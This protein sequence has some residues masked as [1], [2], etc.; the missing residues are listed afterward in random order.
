MSEYD[1]FIRQTMFVMWLYKNAFLRKPE[2]T[3]ALHANEMHREEFT[4]EELDQ[5]CNYMRAVEKES[6]L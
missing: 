4:E 5:I 2:T 3:L 1:N 6:P